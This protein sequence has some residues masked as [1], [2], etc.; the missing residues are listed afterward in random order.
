MAENKTLDAKV[1]ATAINQ[2]NSK[3][4][5]L[6]LATLFTGSSGIPECVSL[7]ED[8]E[9]HTPKLNKRPK[10]ARVKKPK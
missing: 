5:Q 10:R 3:L 8:F 7:R 6:S 1:S 9:L 2:T 4:K